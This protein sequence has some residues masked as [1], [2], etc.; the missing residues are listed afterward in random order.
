MLSGTLTGALSSPS[1]TSAPPAVAPSPR[2][3][4]SA[5]DTDIVAMFESGSSWLVLASFFGFG[6]LLTFTPCVLPM[7]PILSGIIVGEGKDMN[8][9]RALILSLTYVA[10]MSVTYAAAGVAAAY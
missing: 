8:K 2:F 7:I 9:L 5:S 6:L 10:G 1:M 4:I 3:S